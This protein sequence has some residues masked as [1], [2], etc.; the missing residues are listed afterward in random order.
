MG[1]IGTIVGTIVWGGLLWLA[2]AWLI[3]GPKPKPSRPASP[4]DPGAGRAGGS[5]VA[6]TP[7]VARQLPPDEQRL[8][9]DDALVDG[10]VIGHF[11][12][13]DHYERRIGELE[14][15]I[16]ELGHE[17]D[18]WIDGGVGDDDLEH[19]TDYAEFDAMGGFG[20]EPWADDLFDMDDM[21]DE[22]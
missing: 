5:A 19:G 17:R 10:L 20:V 21:D 9:V 4:L 11:L 6:P 7:P 15:S 1:T 13:R 12:T 8:R 14:D 22:D 3:R 16:D 18:P 2:L